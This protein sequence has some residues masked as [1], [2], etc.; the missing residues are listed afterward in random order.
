MP[1]KWVYIAYAA[2]W[3]ATAAGVVVAIVVTQNPWCLAA[4]IIPGYISIGHNWGE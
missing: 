4:F 1:N 3:I 2:A